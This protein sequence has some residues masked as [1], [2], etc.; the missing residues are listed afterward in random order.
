[1]K[2]YPLTP[3]AISGIFW[4][5]T[6]PTPSEETFLISRKT[7][8]PISFHG[9]IGIDGESPYPDPEIM[10]EIVDIHGG[11]SAVFNLRLGQLGT[12]SFDRQYNIQEE[13]R[14]FE[15]RKGDDSVFVG[16]WKTIDQGVT[17]YGGATCILNP[18]P[19]SFFEEPK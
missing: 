2:T 5:G 11:N 14:S 15:F 8:V 19:K 1:M 7:S 12:F 9:I 3:H 10:G 13:L 17:V 4:L 18:L 6:T 16:H